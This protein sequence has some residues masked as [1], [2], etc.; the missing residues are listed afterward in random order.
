MEL[1][2]VLGN[3]LDNAIEAELKNPKG[4]RNIDIS[5]TMHEEVMEI[6][7]KNRILSSVLQANKDLKTTKTNL[8]QHGF[9]MQNIRDIVSKNDGYLDIYEEGEFFCCEVRI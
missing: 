1:C 2:C 9:G 4:Q 3:L 6:L 7:I 8:A 5:V